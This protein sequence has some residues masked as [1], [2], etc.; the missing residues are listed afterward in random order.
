MNSV[1]SF[2]KSSQYFV[3]FSSRESFIVL[4]FKDAKP[5]SFKLRGLSAQE[6]T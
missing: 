4:V 6:N 3:H 2:I 1:I 5:M